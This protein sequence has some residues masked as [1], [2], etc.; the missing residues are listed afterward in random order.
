ML[1]VKHLDLC[2][3]VSTNSNQRYSSR[4]RF[5]TMGIKYINNEGIYQVL[6]DIPDSSSWQMFKQVTLT[7]VTEAATSKSP[8]T[9]KQVVSHM[10]WS[11][12]V[13][14]HSWAQIG[15]HQSGSGDS[16]S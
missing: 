12:C 11:K 15:I 7:T 14:N 2:T 6:M 9:F 10:R 1:L 13:F 5:V 8:L 16:L 3:P 4:A